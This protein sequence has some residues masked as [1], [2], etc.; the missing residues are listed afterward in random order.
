MRAWDFSLLNVRS[1]CGIVFCD[2][3]APVPASTVSIP[4]F[5]EF[6]IFGAVRDRPWLQA[7]E[8][9]EKPK[10]SKELM[11]ITFAQVGF[12]CFESAFSCEICVR[13]DEAQG[14]SLQ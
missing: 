14:V 12:A 4:S 8:N 2:F 5:E 1:D 6:A 10:A 13:A 9:E 3:D 11:Q 7:Y